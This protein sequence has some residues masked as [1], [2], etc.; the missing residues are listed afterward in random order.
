MFFI[1]T[2]ELCHELSQSV[3][4]ENEPDKILGMHRIGSGSE[5][6]KPWITP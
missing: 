2:L 6:V 5:G 3:K 4:F 1:K